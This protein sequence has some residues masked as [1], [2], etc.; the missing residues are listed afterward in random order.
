MLKHVIR[1]KVDGGMG[2]KPQ[3]VLI[4]GRSIGTGPATYLASKFKVGGLIIMSPYTNIKTVAAN[5]AGR[6]LSMFISSHFDNAT[7]M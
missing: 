4:F 2:I 6:F 1:S 3:N 5:V 7:A